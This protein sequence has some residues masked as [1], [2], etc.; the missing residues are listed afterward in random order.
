MNLYIRVENGMPINH[1][2]TEQNLINAFGAVPSEW[3]P[4]VRVEQ[5]IA[6]IY[7]V[8]DQETPTYEKVGNTWT[9][10]WHLRDMTAEEKLAKQQVVK[11]KWAARPN[12]LNW[13]A[14]T[15]NEDTC[16]Y[17]PPIP[18]PADG[19]YFWSGST[20]NWREGVARP[21]DGKDY[22]FDFSQW[23]WVAV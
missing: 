14:W 18:R 23:I 12:L 10:V 8:F 19:F 1:P 7:Q 2:A 13:S 9:D 11:D 16:E 5:P 15:F 4:F 20:N 3:E 21:D 6:L 22:L 17:E